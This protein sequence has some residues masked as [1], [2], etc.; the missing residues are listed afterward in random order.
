M[1]GRQNRQDQKGDRGLSLSHGTEK[2][3]RNLPNR[4]S[5]RYPNVPDFS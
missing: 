2:I 3:G 4:L 5:P 1:T